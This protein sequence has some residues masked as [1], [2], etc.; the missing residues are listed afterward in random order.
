MSLPEL[1]TQHGD[2]LRILAFGR[3]RWQQSAP[4]QRRHPK[5]DESVGSQIYTLDVFRKI[6]IVRREVPTFHGGRTLDAASLPKLSELRS[7]QIDELAVAVG[8]VDHQVDHS[9]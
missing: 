5:M 2:T 4:Q 1:I 8:V 6:T 3:I 9:V 7:I